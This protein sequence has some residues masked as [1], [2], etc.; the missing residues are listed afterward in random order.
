[1]NAAQI[2]RSYE[3]MKARMANYK[4]KAEEALGE[5]IATAEVGGGAF[6]A[7]YA[8]GRY[9]EGG[10][11]LIGGVD[12]DLLLG[13]GLHLT[14]YFGLF[15]KYDEHA[16]NIGNGFVAC[17]LTHKGYELGLEA[18]NQASGYVAPVHELN[19]GAPRASSAFE[20]DFV[21]QAA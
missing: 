5:A 18:K 6:L 17:Y 16:H 21:A 2:Q 14:G 3:S 11:L 8:R 15:G 1:M 13:A 12:G 7:S 4:E 10:R 9:G 20:R 19:V